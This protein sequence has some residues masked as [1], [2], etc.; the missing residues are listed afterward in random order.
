VI[1]VA[2]LLVAFAA[3]VPPGAGALADDPPERLECVRYWPEVRYNG[4][5]YDHWVH[6]ESACTV[7][8]L[9]S[10]VT[11]VNPNATTALVQPGEHAAVLTW[12]ASPAR[13]FSTWVEC[14][15]AA[16]TGR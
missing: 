8:A 1:R 4:G 12:R 5:G 14:L 10:V 3:S 9:C 15:P 16:V 11:N 7:Q 6:L 13:E 2:A